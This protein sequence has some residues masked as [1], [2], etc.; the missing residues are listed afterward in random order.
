MS[1]R[2]RRL[3]RG[4][5]RRNER[6]ATLR[7]VVTRETAVLAVDLAAD[8]QVFA[9]CD[10]DS[11]VLARKTV[12]AKAW[13]L[14][15]AVEWGIS[16]AASA[17]FSSVVV[18]CE[19]TGHRWR[20]LD[21]I[22]TTLGVPL[23]CVQP[24]LV[25]RARV[26]ED[27][28]RNKNDDADAVVIARLVTELR[29][30]LPERAEP[31]WARLRHLGSRRAR[32]VTERGA[33]RQQVRDLLESAWPAAMAAAAQPL[34]SMSWLAATTVALDVIGT[35]G[36]LGKLRSLGWSR[37]AAATRRTLPRFGTTRAFTPVVRAVFDAATQPSLA[38]LGVDD[39]RAGALKR[40]AFC[41]GDLIR[42][43]AE[44]ADVE[45]RILT[46]TDELG[47]TSLLGSIPG[48]SA[49]GGA[50]ILAETGD[51]SR[52][53]SARALVKHA[54]LCPRANESGRSAGTTTISGKGRPGL[55]LAAWRAVF[56]ALRHNPVFLARYTHLTTRADRPLTDTQA[57]VAICASLL[58]Q[59]HA[60]VV[61]ATPWSA[62][63]AAGTDRREEG[64]AQA[65]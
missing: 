47:L 33:A 43:R 34:D 31:A 58:R 1:N 21:Q 64:V 65:A 13:E 38:T 54:G 17:G 7:T 36:D 6:L 44:V 24:L 26:A 15:P 27:L 30:Y 20:V 32:L 63:Q 12:R 10:P 37:F 4:D 40:A 8:K 50:L 59:L 29:C 53:T 62:G 28:T 42:L 45:A 25:G 41:L 9:L 48:I 2:S 18:A 23:V 16:A 56:S 46:V 51:P 52:F 39:Q 55:R 22:T 49:L 61:T 57:R 3:S 19:P 5:Q 11:A 35:S 14:A 60:V